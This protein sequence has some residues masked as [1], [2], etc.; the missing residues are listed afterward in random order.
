VAVLEAAK[1]QWA[2]IYN[3]GKPNCSNGYPD[4]IAAAA[5]RRMNATQAG[6]S[7][8]GGSSA[9]P[10]PPQPVSVAYDPLMRRERGRDLVYHVK[11]ASP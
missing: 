7:P 4:R 10:P 1:R 5:A 8:P 3:T 6:A 11:G 9:S 2:C